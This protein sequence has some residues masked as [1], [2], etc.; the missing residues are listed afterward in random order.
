[1]AFALVQTKFLW[2]MD[3][4]YG[5]WTYGGL[6]LLASL[7]YIITPTLTIQDWIVFV[8][9]CSPA[10]ALLGLQ[11]Y[12]QDNFAYAWTNWYF[13]FA[14]FCFATI[15]I[16]M[17]TLMLLDMISAVG[18]GQIRFRVSELGNPL[19]PELLSD[20]Y[21]SMQDQDLVR[22]GLEALPKRYYDI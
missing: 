1:M 16:V 11:I 3:L 18:E 12:K 10:S 7:Y 15:F 14:A 22:R 5:V 9:V 8:G 17:Q 21:T 6:M 13:S 2:T 19:A 20:K 4:K